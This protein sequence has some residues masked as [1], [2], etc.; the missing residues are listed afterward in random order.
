MELLGQIAPVTRN[1]LRAMYRPPTGPGQ[2]PGLT[3]SQEALFR[4]IAKSSP[5]GHQ[6]LYSEY[7]SQGCQC[8]SDDKLWNLRPGR[9]P[10][11]L[12]SPAHRCNG[13][14]L[15]PNPFHGGLEAVVRNGKEDASRRANACLTSVRLTNLEADLD[16]GDFAG[17]TRERLA[18]YALTLVSIL[19]V[20]SLTATYTGGVS[21]HLI[22]AQPDWRPGMVAEQLADHK[23]WT[24]THYVLR[25]LGI[26]LGANLATQLSPLPDVH[27]PEKP[28]P[29]E[30]LALF[31][32]GSGGALHPER[33]FATMEAL[34]A[35]CVEGILR[36]LPPVDEP[37]VVAVTR[38]RN[39]IGQIA[40]ANRTA[41]LSE[42]NYPSEKGKAGFRLRT[43]AR[44]QRGHA[45]VSTP[46]FAALVANKVQLT[47]DD[48][49]EL[50]GKHPLGPERFW[51]P[52]KTRRVGKVILPKDQA[53]KRQ[54][55][56]TL[57]A[58]LA[59][60][61]Q[62]LHDRIGVE[63]QELCTLL[64]RVT[65]RQLCPASALRPPSGRPFPPHILLPG[66]PCP[67]GHWRRSVLA[68][69][70]FPGKS[71][72]E[73]DALAKAGDVRA[74]KALRALA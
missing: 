65:E 7:K 60:C 2:Q 70:S 32:G 61:G 17:A 28:G 21:T 15:T 62:V 45:Y 68:T 38:T 39:R 35:F 8:W 74:G 42:K 46:E 16:S 71:E 50:F 44:K 1:Q 56:E 57:F 6:L 66:E 53:W 26:D 52:L 67:P 51:G 4:T 29:A 19:P 43:T 55:T 34:L 24:N 72:A 23:N 12:T 48:V 25:A 40:N 13:F 33:P 20:S 49:S 47:P 54:K 31:P 5:T 30:L 41:K 14:W 73:L 18:D 11:A 10:I 9:V 36:Y 3:A 64:R 22:A 69:F 59:W 63:P 27:R 37:K 58:T